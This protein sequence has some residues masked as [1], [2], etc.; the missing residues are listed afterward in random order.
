MPVVSHAQQGPESYF[1][2]ECAQC[3]RQSTMAA[4]MADIFVGASVE[5]ALG[6]PW[7]RSLLC[8][9]NNSRGWCLPSF[10]MK[11]WVKLHSR[12]STGICLC[13]TY[14]LMELKSSLLFLRKAV[15]KPNFFSNC[16][17]D[18]NDLHYW[19]E[20]PQHCLLKTPYSRSHISPRYLTLECL[21]IFRRDS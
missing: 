4:G 20:W 21:S 16:V 8:W 6:P 9:M 18:D 19:V 3:C 15:R 17:L 13:R 5:C 2:P 11:N 12:E 14:H 10:W 7:Q 1:L